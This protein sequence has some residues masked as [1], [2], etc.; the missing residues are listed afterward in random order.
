MLFCFVGVAH[1]AIDRLELFGMGK[2]LSCQIS[3]AGG[4]LECG[5]RRGPQSRRVE[6]RRHS[7]LPLACA[8]SG[9]MAAH[10]RL[11]TRQR[12][13]LLCAEGQSKQERKEGWGE[14][15]K[16]TL[17]RP[18]TSTICR[19]CRPAVVGFHNTS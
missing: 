7:R 11:A 4:A 9:F 15:D 18:N 8:G 3:V 2:L 10:A 5:V 14:S 12:F 6:G 19:R 13:E 1:A 17:P 16:M